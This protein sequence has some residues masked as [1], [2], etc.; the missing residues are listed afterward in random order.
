MDYVWEG[1]EGGEG[2]GEDGVGLGEVEFGGGRGWF[3]IFEV[4]D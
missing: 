3:R 1:G 4:V 2:F